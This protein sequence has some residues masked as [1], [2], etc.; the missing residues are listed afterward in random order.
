MLVLSDCPDR[1]PDLARH[2]GWLEARVDL[3]SAGERALWRALSPSERLWCGTARAPG[4]PGF[5]SCAVV[6]AEAPSSQFD[7]L[8]EQL[9]RGLQLPG[10][11]AC[12]ALSGRGFHGQ[13]DRPWLSAPGN[14]HLCVAF[15]EPGLAAREARALPMLP[16]LALVDAVPAMTGG[17]LRPGIKWV[18]D[19]LLDG[20]KIGG[21]LTATQTQEGRVRALL[22][23]LGLNVATAPPVPSTPFVP[24]VGC[25]A[26]AGSRV[27]LTD[28]L[29]CVLVALGRRMGDVVERGPGALLEAYRDASLVLGREVCLFEDSAGG[30]RESRPSPLLRGTVRAIN[31]DLSLVV[32]GVAA[33][34]SSGRLAFAEDCIPLGP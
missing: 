24:S 29:A 11:V 1:L 9:A 32:E 14:L 30:E 16:A 31:A 19:V 28:A 3:L 26:D 10:P 18:N 20:R 13:R 12:L 27:G 25:L 22:L 6:V 2:A 33:P 7:V 34:V 5:W 23:G 21:V 4:P 15:P 8:R 17:A